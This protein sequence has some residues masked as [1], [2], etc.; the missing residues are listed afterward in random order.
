MCKIGG[1][2][3]ENELIPIEFRLI[4]RTVFRKSVGNRQ[5]DWIQEWSELLGIMGRV[6]GQGRTAKVTENTVNPRRYFN[7]TRN[8]SLL[9][10]FEFYFVN[11]RVL[12]ETQLR[13]ELLPAIFLLADEI[14][15][16]RMN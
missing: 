15:L 9:L 7:K 2:S 11:L 1:R 14:L 10:L 6:E 8:C 5:A 13:R 12:V 16:G 3:G 4:R